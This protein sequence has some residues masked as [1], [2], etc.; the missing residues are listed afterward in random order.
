MRELA[1]RFLCMI[2]LVVSTVSSAFAYEQFPDGFDGVKFGSVPPKTFTL[3][4][5]ITMTR[6]QKAPEI[7]YKNPAATTNSFY[8][9]PTKEVG[10]IFCKN[11]L[12]EIQLNFGTKNILEVKKYLTDKLGLAPKEFPPTTTDKN[13]RFFWKT[14]DVSMELNVSS[15]DNETR[16]SIYSLKYSDT[17]F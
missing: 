5:K 1:T 17:C 4:E 9:L 3:Q 6:G 13:P 7:L 11:K 10:Y 2:V 14:P 12:L 8:G 16:I 15:L